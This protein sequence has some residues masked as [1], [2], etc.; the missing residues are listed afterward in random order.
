M[1]KENC[2]VKYDILFVMPNGATDKD[3]N[4]TVRIQRKKLYL[5]MS[6]VLLNN[7]ILAIYGL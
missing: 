4:T 1:N 3:K 7:S 6:N 5:R 2:S